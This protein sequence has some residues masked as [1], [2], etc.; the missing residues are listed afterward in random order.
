MTY[1][2]TKKSCC[3]ITNEFTAEL[4][5]QE[6]SFCGTTTVCT[7]SENVSSSDV[8]SPVPLFST[9][10]PIYTTTLNVV[11]GYN[12]KVLPPNER[13]EYLPGDIIGWIKSSSSATLVVGSNH[14]KYSVLGSVT[15]VP[16]DN[17]T[18]QRENNHTGT[19]LLAGIASKPTEF[20]ANISAPTSPG[21]KNISFIHKT[22]DE[23][24]ALIRSLTALYPVGNVSF[25]MASNS[26]IMYE[27]SNEAFNISIKFNAGTD[28]KVT[29]KLSNITVVSFPYLTIGNQDETNW[30]Q[31]FTISSTGEYPLVVMVT[32]GVSGKVVTATV[33]IQEKITGV[34]ANKA[35]SNKTAY[36]GFSTRLNVSILT[37]TNVT[38]KWY[39]GDGSD[40]VTLTNTTV[41]HLYRKHGLI[42]TTVEATNMVSL[43]NY[44]FIIDITNP[45]EITVPSYA[46][47]NVSANIT[48]RIVANLL[49]TYVI[50]LQVDNES[51]TSSNCNTI[52]HVFT[53]G[54]H[55]IHCYIHMV[56]VL[57]SNTSLFA[58]EPISGL[59]ILGIRP[60]ELNANYTVEANI[61]AGNNVSYEWITTGKM[62]HGNPTPIVFDEVGSVDVKVIAFNAIS[63]VSAETVVIVQEPIGELNITPSANPAKTDFNITFDINPTAQSGSIN[64]AV[65]VT[66]VQYRFDG[67]PSSKFSHKFTEEGIY[68]VFVFANNLIDSTNATYL[69][70]VQVS[71]KQPPNITCPS[72]YLKEK[73][74]CVISTDYL[75]S[76]K[77]EI[78][79]AT[80][81]TFEWKWGENNTTTDSS[82]LKNEFVSISSTRSKSFLDLKTFDITVKAKNKV[83]ELIKTLRVETLDNVT[84]FTFICPRA[85][86]VNTSF[87]IVPKIA[88]GSNVTYS[89]VFGDGK[90]GIRTTSR[91]ASWRYTDVG[92]YQIKGNA[93]NL[94]SSSQFSNKIFVQHEITDVS[95]DKIKTVATHHNASITW[96]VAGGTNV[97]SNVS[98]EDIG[99]NK[100]INYKECDSNLTYTICTTQHK[101]SKS[102]SYEVYIEAGNRLTT[103]KSATGPVTVQGPIEG[104]TVYV[105]HV[106][107][108]GEKDKY[109]VNEEIT[110]ICEVTNGTDMTYQVNQ[111]DGQVF[112]T[113]KRNFTIK[114]FAV[115][116]YQIRAKAFNDI[117][118]TAVVTSDNIKII[119]RP[120]PVQIEGLKLTVKPTKFNEV[121]RFEVEYGEGAIFECLLDFGDG[122]NEEIIEENLKKGAFHRY[123]TAKTYTAI[124]ECWN[125]PGKKNRK[126]EEETVY[127]QKPIKDFRLKETALTEKYKKE[128]GVIIDFVWVNGSDMDVIAY[129][130]NSDP[131]LSNSINYEERKGSIVLPTSYFSSPDQYIILVNASNKVSSLDKPEEVTVNIIEK[132]KGAKVLFNEWVSVKYRLRAYLLVDEGSDMVVTW[133]FGDGTSSSTI[134]CTWKESCSHDHTYNKTG[135]FEISAKAKNELGVTESAGSI[136]IQYPIFGWKFRPVNISIAGTPSKVELVYNSSYGFPTDARYEIIFDKDLSGNYKNLSESITREGTVRGQHKYSE[137]GCYDVSAKMEND[138]SKVLLETTIKVRGT[139][140]KVNI[141]AQSLKGETES[142]Q[143]VLPLEYPVKFQSNIVNSCL[144][145]NWTITE[146]ETITKPGKLLTVNRSM[147]FQYTFNASGKYRINL[148]AYDSEDI[149]DN[150]TA[151]TNVTVDKSAT[152]LFLSS[153]GVGKVNDS[154]QFILLWATLGDST[155][156][157]VDYGDGELPLKTL[158]LENKTKGFKSYRGKL[159]FD[160]GDLEGIIFSHKFSQIHQFKVRVKVNG[161]FKLKTLVTVTEKPCPLPVIT[162]TGGD[163]DANRAPQV[164][165]ETEYTIFSKVEW[166]SRSGCSDIKID[167]EW[168]I[169]KADEYLLKTTGLSVI[170][171]EKNREIK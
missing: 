159:P 51:L 37:G 63:N 141:T 2:P 140:K 157:S 152:G 50:V 29:W 86:A 126:K 168:R 122:N 88:K 127:V 90:V 114:Y 128:E 76:F 121:T 64:Y 21:V 16:N 132:I 101:W 149:R 95:I 158:S 165:Y 18:L 100:T 56:I 69:I 106:G 4:C 17:I 116:D 143:R 75:W 49:S 170:P 136:T 68:T 22:S 45:V 62:Y 20:I 146:L 33:I 124:L 91:N 59:S 70:T 27:R 115:G 117:S 13:F 61:S 120:E 153:E 129:K 24:S 134:N 118:S 35:D 3:Q 167:F 147:S 105:D 67:Q 6:T 161:Q 8:N 42:N 44:S 23:N 14:G 93:S 60:L 74:T 162:V 138:V 79:Y 125:T 83:S 48:C 9:Y 5:N 102:G 40:A 166:D 53:P 133:N 154:I 169:F 150:F 34:T 57:Y 30:Q 73:R 26:C 160:P 96:K 72:V 156:F 99:P 54:D 85:V 163:K 58:V 130:N 11:V 39:F 52:Q 36:Q 38:Y 87:D 94:V 142:S 107:E 112:N 15:S 103:K 80:N 84:S 131:V 155:K 41:D 43:V 108:I 113:S 139:Y 46:V 82:P 28:A 55:D 104:L 135:R 25:T 1:C 66:T 32:N 98:F 145:Y 148:I 12:I 65:N 89:Y 111:A 92:V 171:P 137:P 7:S 144:K 31:N 119:Q 110:V 77:A 81:V 10:T 47:S 123:K 164:P 19:V 151:E 97:T 78:P 109:Y 71:V